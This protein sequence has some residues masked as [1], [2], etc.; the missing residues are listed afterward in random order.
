MT[1]QSD[2]ITYDIT[3]IRDTPVYDIIIYIHI[4]IYIYIYNVDVNVTCFFN[5]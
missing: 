5:A 4:Y 1:N 2:I 3:C